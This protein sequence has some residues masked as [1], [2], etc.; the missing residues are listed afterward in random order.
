VKPPK[1]DRGLAI[2]A[3]VVLLVPVA[4]F[5]LLDLLVQMVPK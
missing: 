4:F 2:I 5:V 1:Y 3:S